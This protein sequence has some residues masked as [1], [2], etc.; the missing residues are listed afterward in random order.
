MYWTAC[1]CCLRR[2]YTF[3]EKSIK[4]M[5]RLVHTR[6]QMRLLRW[7]CVWSELAASVNSFFL[8]GNLSPGEIKFTISLCCKIHHHYEL[9]TVTLENVLSFPAKCVSVRMPAVSQIMM[10]R[11]GHLYAR[12]PPHLYTQTCICKQKALTQEYV[13]MSI[14]T[15]CSSATFAQHLHTNSTNTCTVTPHPPTTHHC[16]SCEDTSFSVNNCRRF[17]EPQTESEFVYHQV[18]FHIQAVME[19]N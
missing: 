1:P 6:A 19:M 13:T 5:L 12:S 4:G 7:E 14:S 18:C 11:D 3:G 9:I 16:R 8:W 2:F 15:T 10:P 17:E